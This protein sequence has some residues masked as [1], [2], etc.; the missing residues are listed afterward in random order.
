MRQVW[1]AASIWIWSE[2]E[3]VSA[4]ARPPGCARDSSMLDLGLDGLAG[5]RESRSEPGLRLGEKLFAGNVHV[6]DVA[7][8]PVVVEGL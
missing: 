4:R 2:R 5:L 6:R 1:R 8:H 7:G 3:G